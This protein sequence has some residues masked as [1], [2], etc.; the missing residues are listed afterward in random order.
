MRRFFYATKQ[1]F[2]E[3]GKHEIYTTSSNFRPTEA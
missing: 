2:D 3:E 1:S